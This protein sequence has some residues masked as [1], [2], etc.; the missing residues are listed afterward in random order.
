MHFFTLSYKSIVVLGA[1]HFHSL[2]STSVLKSF[3]GI[4]TQHGLSKIGVKSIENGLA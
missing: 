2:K 4:D 1:S 3:H